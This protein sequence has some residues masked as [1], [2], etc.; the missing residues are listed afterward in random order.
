M[1]SSKTSDD[2]A[3][4]PGE[5]VVNCEHLM[6]YVNEQ[7]AEGTNPAPFATGKLWEHTSIIPVLWRPR[8]VRAE[9][10]ARAAARSS[11]RAQ[12]ASPRMPSCVRSERRSSFA[13]HPAASTRR[14]QQL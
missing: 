11:G 12:R 9:R 1:P 6:A 7:K 2:A 5:L 8:A 4:D 13:A 14:L 3:S 10:G